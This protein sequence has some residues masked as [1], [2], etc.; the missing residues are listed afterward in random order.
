[1]GMIAGLFKSQSDDRKDEKSKRRDLEKEVGRL[2]KQK[3]A[4][5]TRS[6]G[7]ERVIRKRNESTSS[8]GTG[9]LAG[10]EE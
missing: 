1:M 4:A 5:T 2:K 9:L 8:V 3:Q 10:P 7:L 6:R